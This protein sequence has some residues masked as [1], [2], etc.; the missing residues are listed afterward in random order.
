[1]QH[2]RGITSWLNVHHDVMIWR[3]FLYYWPF[4]RGIDQWWYQFF[5][6]ATSI[7]TW[8]WDG[9]FT[10]WTMDHIISIKKAVAQ[11]SF[12]YQLCSV[13]VFLWKIDNIIIGPAV[14]HSQWDVHKWCNIHSLWDVH[15]WCD[16]HDTHIIQQLWYCCRH[17]LYHSYIGDVCA[18]S[19]DIHPNP[20]MYMISE[21]PWVD[22]PLG[23]YQ[24]FLHCWRAHQLLARI[25]GQVLT[26]HIHMELHFHKG[27]KQ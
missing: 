14:R 2:N 10:M 3:C 15:K 21:R 12:W 25:M 18:V 9:T 1:M 4:V 7:M 22:Q 11:L 23:A 5:I 19:L 16:I 17:D 26:Y 24:S 13:Q 27:R 8:Y 20:I 6:I